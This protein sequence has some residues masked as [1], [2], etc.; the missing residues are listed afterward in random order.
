MRDTDG[1]CHCTF[2]RAYA[3][4]QSVGNCALV[5]C[6]SVNLPVPFVNRKPADATR[7]FS[8]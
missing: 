4:I 3:T 7:W 5:E 2:W 1:Q 6:V 8:R